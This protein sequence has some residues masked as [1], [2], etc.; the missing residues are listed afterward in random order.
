MR[1][2]DKNLMYPVFFQVV[3][4]DVVD[5]ARINPECPPLLSKGKMKCWGVLM[6]FGDQ[7][8]NV[9]KFS[10]S[11]PFIKH[12]PFLDLFDLGPPEK[13]DRSKVPSSTPL[14]EL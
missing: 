7:K 6:D 14:A 9:K 11:A 13:F 10:H 4:C 12:S 2:S 1:S 5:L 8:V 3:L